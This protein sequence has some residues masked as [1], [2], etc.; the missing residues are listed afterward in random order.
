[1]ANLFEK[2]ER[3]PLRQLFLSVFSV[4]LMALNNNE[5]L[6]TIPSAYIPYRLFLIIFSIYVL[7]K[8]VLL[9]LGTLKERKDRTVSQNLQI[10]FIGVALILL[11]FV[12]TDMTLHT[13]NYISTI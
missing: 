4:A 1:M 2:K 6:S 13:V 9:I 7:V 3:S 5:K 11:V 10:L 12:A 8:G